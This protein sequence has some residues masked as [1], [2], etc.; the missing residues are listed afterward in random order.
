MYGW[1]VQVMRASKQVIFPRIDGCLCAVAQSQTVED[2]GNVVFHGTLANYEGFCYFAVGQEK[3]S[4]C[5]RKVPTELR[6]SCKA[7]LDRRLASMI[8]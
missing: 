3:S 8:A 2:I 4:C 5:V 7:S 6:I 1:Q